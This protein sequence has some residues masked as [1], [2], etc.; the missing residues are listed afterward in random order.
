MGFRRLPFLNPQTRFH[1]TMKNLLITSACLYQGEHQ[2]VGTELDNVDN[3]IAADL[4]SAGRAV[5]RYV[6]HDVIGTRDPVVENRDPAPAPA[7]S[8][9]A[10]KAAKGGAAAVTTPPENA[11]EGSNNQPPE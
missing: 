2:D 4:I 8:K 1:H 3:H 7:P 10:K 6:P 5:E 11:P 9:P